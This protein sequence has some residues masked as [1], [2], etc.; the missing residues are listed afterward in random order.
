[1]REFWSH[2]TATRAAIVVAFLGISSL[3][4]IGIA[5]VVGGARLRSANLFGGPTP[6]RAGSLG[7]ATK[8]TPSVA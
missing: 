3:Y 7:G 1:M 8:L 2:P 6:V 5:S 4:C